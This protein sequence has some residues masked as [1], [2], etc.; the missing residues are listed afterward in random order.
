MLKIERGAII[1]LFS[2]LGGLL[3]F[4]QLVHGNLALA[5]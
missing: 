2:E 5:D 4:S 1:I 3:Q